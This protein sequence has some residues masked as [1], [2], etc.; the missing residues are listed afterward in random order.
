MDIAP[1]QQQF[2]SDASTTYDPAGLALKYGV[3][4]DGELKLD[5]GDF[6]GSSNNCHIRQSLGPCLRAEDSTVGRRVADGSTNDTPSRFTGGMSIALQELQNRNATLLE[7]VEEKNRQ[8]LQLGTLVEALEPV[9]GLDPDAFISVL[10]G[11]SGATRA[12]DVDYRDVKVVHLAKRARALNARLEGEKA[13]CLKARQEADVLARELEAC[14]RQ[15]ELVSSAGA[16]LAAEKGPRNVE[17]AQ[18]SLSNAGDDRVSGKEERLRQQVVLLRNKLRETQEEL[19]KSH[20]AL[21]K[22]IGSSN[23][24]LGRALNDEGGWKGRAQQIVMLHARVKQL[25]ARLRSHGKDPERIGGTR[26]I[27][28]GQNNVDSQAQEDINFLE[29]QRRRAIE[30][31]EEKHKVLHEEAEALR[32]RVMAKGA[33]VTGL[34]KANAQ[35]RDRAKMLL[36]KSDA[37]DRLIDA[38]RCEVQA[39]RE[40]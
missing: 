26:V 38:L 19:K 25:E 10:R 4:G 29:C 5:M 33:R 37:D 8:V 11:G 39:L 9:P 13:R 22:E 35:I 40:R 30:Q 31:L 21:S 1:A 36:K 2:A 32:G 27:Q 20:R 3:D 17:V 23:L 6:D 34:E 14:R 28:R 15:L 7:A 24:A 12:N 18:V 16:R